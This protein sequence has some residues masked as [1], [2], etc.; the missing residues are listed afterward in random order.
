M[1]LALEW[2]DRDK[3]S[4]G[5]GGSVMDLDK[6]VLSELTCLQPGLTRGQMQ[7][8]DKPWGSHSCPAIYQS[9]PRPWSKAVLSTAKAAFKA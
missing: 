5:Q 8:E 4:L 2:E 7:N 6:M 3:V 1:S 9:P